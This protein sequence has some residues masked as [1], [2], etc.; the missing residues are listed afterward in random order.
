MIAWGMREHV[1]MIGEGE[2][3]TMGDLTLLFHEEVVVAWDVM[4]LLLEE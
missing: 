4:D 2:A 1:G 3:T